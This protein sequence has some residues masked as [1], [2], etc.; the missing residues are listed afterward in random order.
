MSQEKKPF[1]LQSLDCMGCGRL[2]QI[3]Y[4]IN[5]QLFSL[6][7]SW[8]FRQV[9]HV[10]NSS[11]IRRNEEQREH[12]KSKECQYKGVIESDDK[13]IVAVSLCDGMVSLFTSEKILHHREVAR[14]E[15]R[16]WHE[17]YPHQLLFN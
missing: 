10:W 7:V 16:P 9:T 12:L 2:T 13:S 14:G 6:S 8:K 1:K 5:N 4:P 3:N 11:N 15:N 17:I